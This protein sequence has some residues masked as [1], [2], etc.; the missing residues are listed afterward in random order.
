MRDVKTHNIDEFKRAQT[1]FYPLGG[2]EGE[3]P[4]ITVFTPT[5][6]RA[7]ILLKLYESLC[8]QTCQ[9]FEWLF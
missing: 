6:N 5:Y 2:G 3:H 9:N 1:S 4:T 8:A 7:Y